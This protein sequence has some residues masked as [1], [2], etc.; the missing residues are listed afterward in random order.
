MRTSEEAQGLSAKLQAQFVRELGGR[1]PVVDQV[2]AGNFGN[3]YRV[4]VG[5]FAASRET[6]E[7]CE[8]L[9]LGGLDCRI[10]SQ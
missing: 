5:P 2:A 3:F 4:Q 9:K 8:K 6:E 10:V 1:A 7:L